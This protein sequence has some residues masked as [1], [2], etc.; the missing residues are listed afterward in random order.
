MIKDV[1]CRH[2]NLKP[3]HFLELNCLPNRH[4]YGNGSRPNDDVASGIAEA[5]R[6]GY[7]GSRVKPVQQAGIADFN[8]LA[9]RH[10]RMQ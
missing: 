7:E 8:G 6:W 1:A 2:A 4:I 9:R 3:L 10:V 5:A